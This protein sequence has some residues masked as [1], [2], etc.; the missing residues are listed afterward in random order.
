MAGHCAVWD[1]GARCVQP[2]A[3]RQW[4]LRWRA[5]MAECAALFCP[6]CVTERFWIVKSV[7]YWAGGAPRAVSLPNI[8]LSR[9]SCMSL[10]KPGVLTRPRPR[11]TPV[12]GSGTTSA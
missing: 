12:S 5:K 9:L 4:L 8:M 11:G 7:G 10:A 2:L 3:L 1:G 6:T